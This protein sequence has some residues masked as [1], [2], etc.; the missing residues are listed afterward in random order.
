MKKLQIA[1]VASSLLVAGTAFAESGTSKTGGT[2]ST[3]SGSTGS[4][5]TGSSSTGSSS[6]GSSSGSTMGTSGTSSTTMGANGD[7]DSQVLIQLHLANQMEIDAGNLA[8][9]QAQ[10]KDVKSFAK[11]L[12]RDHKLADK[13][14]TELAKNKKVKLIETSEI[15][16]MGSTNSTGSMNS[17]GSTGSGS[18]NSTG[19]TG[20]GSM[21]S[22]GSTGSMASSSNGM[23]VPGMS[24]FHEAMMNMDKMK[25]MTGSE[26]DRTFV[27]A[28]A[29]DH[30]KVIDLIKGE[31][32][33]IK[34]SKVKTLAS[35]ALKV[36]EGHKKTA[37]KL[38][39]T[40]RQNTSGKTDSST[41][42][43]K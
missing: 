36:V 37:D 1:L 12:V 34:D 24:D 28:M 21:G 38:S 10:S 41:S 6:T 15:A 26:F 7:V 23:D 3:G 20:S 39:K 33:Q 16:S 27:S 42:Y 11:E 35:G 8:E 43:G 4:S 22:T 14:V 2:T 40:D 13:G 19:S 32:G 25:S 9:K 30:Q 17:T 29:A 31:Q 5:S 18:M